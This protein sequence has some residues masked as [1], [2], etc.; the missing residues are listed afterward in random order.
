M[1]SGL[2]CRHLSDDIRERYAILIGRGWVPKDIWD[3]FDLSRSIGS[4]MIIYVAPTTNLL[5]M[6]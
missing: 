1:G 5:P 2:A 4:S 6:I 3:V